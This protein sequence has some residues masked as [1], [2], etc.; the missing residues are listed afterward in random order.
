MDGYLLLL[1][2]ILLIYE[3]ALIFTNSLFIFYSHTPKSVKIINVVSVLLFIIEIFIL[4]IPIVFIFHTMNIPLIC[5]I[6]CMIPD[7]SIDDNINVY[8]KND[9]YINIEA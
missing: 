9:N 8:S 1:N 2:I 3:I 6:F 5:H 4:N 7:N